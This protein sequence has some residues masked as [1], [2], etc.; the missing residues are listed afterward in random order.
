METIQGFELMGGLQYH[1][2]YEQSA[3]ELE[4]VFPKC[5]AGITSALEVARTDGAETPLAEVA[6][7]G[8]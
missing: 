2:G 4:S 7:G 8:V 6:E 3:T 5:A 1:V